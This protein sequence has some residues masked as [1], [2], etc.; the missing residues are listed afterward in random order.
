[1]AA[2]VLSEHDEDTM[3]RVYD[4]A[5]KLRPGRAVVDTTVNLVVRGVL[6]PPVQLQPPAAL[7]ASP[8]PT[9][10]R[11]GATPFDDLDGEDLEGG[12]G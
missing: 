9:T 3:L 10:R 1:M 2:A 12:P 5:T 8:R 6:T 11:R 7:P 4:A